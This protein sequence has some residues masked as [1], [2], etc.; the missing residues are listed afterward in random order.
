VT[1]RRNLRALARQSKGATIVEFALIL[2]ALCVT[3]LGFFDL[4]YHAY[5][6]SIVEGA[7]HEAARSATVGGKTGAQIDALVQSRLQSFSKGATIT[8]NKTS[9]DNFADVGQPEKITTDTAPL[10]VYNK[11]DCF[12]DDNGNGTWDADQ[13]KGGLGGADDIVDYQIVMTYPRLVPIGKFLG[14]SNTQTITEATVLRNQPYAQQN[15][16]TPIVCT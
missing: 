3:L 8:I 7:L 2:P 4:G 1:M 16:P 14:W 12:E 5:V 6:L 10:G 13:G 9:Y 11:G 15:D